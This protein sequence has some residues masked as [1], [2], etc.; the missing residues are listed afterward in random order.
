MNAHAL[1]CFIQCLLQIV[2]V[3]SGP[4]S[5]FKEKHSLD[6]D[7]EDEGGDGENISKYDILANDDVEGLCIVCSHADY[8]IN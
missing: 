6:S 4:G 5:R 7:E 3:V 8:Q 2:D 1:F